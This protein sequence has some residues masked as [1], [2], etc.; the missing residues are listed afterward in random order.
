MDAAAR[1]HP[2][3]T[4]SQLLLEHCFLLDP[5]RR[6]PTAAAR[7]EALLGPEL[8]RRLVLALCKPV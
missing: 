5:G 8:A 7:L 6:R 3:P 1:S 2:K 4:A